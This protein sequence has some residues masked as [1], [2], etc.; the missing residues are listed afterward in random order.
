MNI[1]NQLTLARLVLTM[2]VLGISTI[3]PTADGS[4]LFWWRIGLVLAA[5]AGITDLLDGWIARRYNL[6]TT[7][8]KLIDPLADK[9]FTVSCYVILTEHR[10]CPAWVTVAILTREFAVTGLRSIAISKGRVI[11]A[12]TIGKWKTALQMGG[13]FIGGLF[14]VELVPG[15]DHMG[16]PAWWPYL[17]YFIAIFTLYTGWAYFWTNRDMVFDEDL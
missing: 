13:L 17:L 16:G 3:E 2:V 9:V 12:V 11:A 14:W 7:F 6:V 8:G 15:G 1:P 5:I 4:H 10:L